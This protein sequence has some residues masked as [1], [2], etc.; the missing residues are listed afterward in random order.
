MMAFLV[1]GGTLSSRYVEE[2]ILLNNILCTWTTAQTELSPGYD[3]VQWFGI[4][5]RFVKMNY[6]N[7]IRIV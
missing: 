5:A 6:R 3:G 7:H 1:S 4:S 2:K